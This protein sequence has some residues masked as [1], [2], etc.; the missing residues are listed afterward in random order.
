MCFYQSVDYLFLSFFKFFESDVSELIVIGLCSF[1]FS[2]VIFLKL[3]VSPV[4]L[5]KLEM[6]NSFNYSFLFFYLTYYFCG[7]FITFFISYIKFILPI[8]GSFL[9]FF[10]FFL[11]F[12]MIFLIYFLFNFATVKIFFAL[13]TAI[14]LTS[15]MFILILL[16]F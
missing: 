7:F 10:L 11:F 9:L 16:F 1:L 14:N 2:L 5:F 13:S 12:S 4:H 3:G 6:Y 8:S 15:F